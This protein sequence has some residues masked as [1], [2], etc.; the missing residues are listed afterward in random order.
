MNER[1]TA[2]RV[3]RVV[4]AMVILL[5]CG[6]VLNAM[7]SCL[8]LNFQLDR[9]RVVKADPPFQDWPVEVPSTWPYMPGATNEFRAL[10]F[11]RRVGAAFLV[12]Y[13]HGQASLVTAGL[14]CAGVACSMQRV[15]PMGGSRIATPTPPPT[16]TVENG[17]EI[18]IG[19]GRVIIPKRILG[20][21]FVVDSIAHAALAWGVWRG[22][23]AGRGYVRRR[24][25]R[26][27]KCN[28]DRAGIPLD[29]KCPE[30]GRA[31]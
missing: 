25:N 8:L 13:S 23:V 9:A 15:S 17:W 26:C 24:G 30:C 21:G 5:P 27:V 16:E 20:R 12:G 28:Y 2:I 1:P 3:V 6:V 19:K 14:P 22:V 10:G 18:K 29:A 7:T 11:R 4:C 31:P